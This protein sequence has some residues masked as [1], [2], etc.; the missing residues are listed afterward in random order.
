M[1]ERTV[2]GRGSH[3]AAPYPMMTVMHGAVVSQ[4]RA[5]V[6]TVLARTGR[7]RID[8][9]F[10][11]GP[12]SSA[13][14]DAA[15]AV[16]GVG[17][18]RL[19][20][21]DH[22][23]AHSAA[24]VAHVRSWAAQRGVEL[25]LAVVVVPTGASWEA[26]AR[27]VRHAA[28]QRLAGDELIATGHTASDHA[29]TVLM[30]IVRGTGPDGLAAIRA[31]S[32]PWVRPLLSITRAQVAAYCDGLALAPWHDP[33][34]DDPRFT[35]VWMR[36]R[37][38]PMLT[39]HNPQLEAALVRLAAAAADDQQALAP[40]V[41]ALT[42]AAMVDVD[43]DCRALS[44]APPAIARRV[45]ADWL[46]RHGRSAE[47]DVCATVLA[48]ATAPT[49]GTRGL[50]VSGGRVERVYD[51][52]VISGSPGP[53]PPALAV[54]GDSGPYQVRVWLPG[55]RMRPARLRGSSR[56]LSDLY[57]DRKLPRADRDHARVVVAGDGVIVWAEHIGVAWQAQVVV[58]FTPSPR[59]HCPDG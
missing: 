41:A 24:A 11:G 36:H 39:A 26:Q 35:R 45:I 32:G 34:N 40:A 59:S 54:T 56:K 43:L 31:R 25:E 15:I 42:T 28:L 38:M 30:R 55:D 29:E 13:L 44:A 6:A 46:R 14:A 8:V 5:T 33:M 17:A 7:R 20:H 18:V 57:G 9:G 53:V 12:D 2:G 21:V 58:G 3:G 51:R 49:A 1:S 22:G 27:V 37:V 4:V 19:L 48:L 50:D 47:L 23:V 52:L 10:S 16:L